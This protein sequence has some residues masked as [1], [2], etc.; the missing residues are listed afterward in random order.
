VQIAVFATST[1]PNMT[2]R[3]GHPL[4]T[5]SN[6]GKNPKLT[7][8]NANPS[9]INRA[10]GRWGCGCSQLPHVHDLLSLG[11]SFDDLAFFLATIFTTSQFIVTNVNIRIRKV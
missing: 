4:A 5:K 3:M 11:D 6:C 7:G 1:T 10:P 9:A 8:R 2:S